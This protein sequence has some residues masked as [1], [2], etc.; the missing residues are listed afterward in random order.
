VTSQD[1]ASDKRW[2]FVGELASMASAY[3]IGELEAF[4][5]QVL[6]LLLLLLLPLLPVSRACGGW[7]GCAGG[8]EPLRAVLVLF[9][10]GEVSLGGILIIPLPLPLPRLRLR[11]LALLLYLLQK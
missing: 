3:R 11:L 5:D 6:V 7:G 8:G 9:W 1:D 10:C 2:N 4:L